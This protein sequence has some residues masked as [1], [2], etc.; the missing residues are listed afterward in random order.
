MP[1]IT[2][3]ISAI[4][5][6]LVE[7]SRIICTTLSTTLPPRCAVSEALKRKMLAGLARIFGVL[8]HRCGQLLHAGCRLFQRSGLLLGARREIV[9]A[10]SDSLAPL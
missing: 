5:C 8:F 9:I 3:I 6:E 10:G 7:I 4:F 1:S 2:L